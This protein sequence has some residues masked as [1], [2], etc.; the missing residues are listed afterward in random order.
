LTAYHPWRWA[1]R[2]DIAAQGID[3]FA[4]RAEKYGARLAP[5]EKLGREFYCDAGVSEVKLTGEKKAEK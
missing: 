3:G 1:A 4:Q 2:F 5:N